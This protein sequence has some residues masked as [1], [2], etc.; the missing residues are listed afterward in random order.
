MGKNSAIKSLGKCIGNIV[1]H[2]LLLNHTNRPESKNHLMG[3]VNDYGADAK[4]KAQ[5][6][7]WTDEEKAEIEDKAFRRV[8]NIVEKYPDLE[9]EESEINSLILETMGGLF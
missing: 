5:E 7:S 8:K 4:E 2:K 1:L 6:H 9:Y 3:E